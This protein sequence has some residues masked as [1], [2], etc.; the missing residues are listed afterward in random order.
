[1]DQWV[2]QDRTDIKYAVK[3]LRLRIMS[4]LTREDQDRLKI[5]GTY[6]LLHRR[7]VQKFHYQNILS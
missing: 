3:E 6:L 1:M 5:L 4:K 2:S 7:V